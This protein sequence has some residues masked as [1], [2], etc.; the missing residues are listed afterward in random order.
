MAVG[1][2]AG[3]A[4]GLAG[5]LAGGLVAC[6]LARRDDLSARLAFFASRAITA[7]SLPDAPALSHRDLFRLSAASRPLS[8]AASMASLTALLA[9]LA[10]ERTA[11][12]IKL[13]GGSGLERPRRR[14]DAREAERRAGLSTAS[15]SMLRRAG[16]L[17]PDL[18]VARAARR[19]R[20]TPRE[21]GNQRV[22]SAGSAGEPPEAGRVHG[23][24]SRLSTGASE[25]C[26]GRQQSGQRYFRQTLHMKTVKGTLTR[27]SIPSSLALILAR[28]ALR[29]HRWHRA[30]PWKKLSGTRFFLSRS[31]TVFPGTGMLLLF[32]AT[33]TGLPCD[34]PW[35]GAG[36]GTTMGASCSHSAH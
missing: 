10:G 17:P 21:G 26:H 11:G 25:S 5:G 3:L 15:S 30:W 28:L 20:R 18:A 35:P 1:L 12:E 36:A 9:F 6:R 33:L 31:Y 7:A 8:T 4:A 27:S 2:A 29:L 16:L 32:L 14:G 19:P 24:H 34:T 23:A 22:S 13:E